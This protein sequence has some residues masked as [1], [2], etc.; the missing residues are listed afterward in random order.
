MWQE[1]TGIP[2]KQI[3]VLITTDN[4]EIQEYV[5]NPLRFVGIL[6]EKIDLYFDELIKVTD[7]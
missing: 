3:V 4:G 1:R 5:E 7:Q 6:K 2:I